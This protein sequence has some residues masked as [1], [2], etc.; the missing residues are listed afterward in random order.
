MN[1][2][3]N[4]ESKYQ[5]SIEKIISNYKTRIFKAWAQWCSTSLYWA[6]SDILTKPPTTLKC[7]NKNQRLRNQSNLKQFLALKDNNQQVP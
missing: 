2:Q 7:N 3:I 6:Q 1:L 5:L 4:H